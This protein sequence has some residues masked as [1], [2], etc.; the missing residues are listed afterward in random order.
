MAAGDA[1]PLPRKNAAF[2]WTFEMRDLLGALVTGAAGLDS[3]VSKDGGAF[4]DCTNEATEIGNGVYYL[5][6]TSTEMNADCVAVVVKTSTS[7]AIHPTI[8]LY[9]AEDADIRTNGVMQNGTAL[10]ARDMGASVL[11]SPGTGTGQVDLSAGVVKADNALLKTT[12]ATLYAQSIFDLAAGPSTNSAISG[13]ELLIRDAD[14]LTRFTSVVCNQYV[15]S[16]KNV[17]LAAG[18]TPAFTI[19]VG[20]VVYVM[21][22]APLQP[23]SHGRKITVDSL[24]QVAVGSMAADSITAA[25]I[26]S[27]AFTAAKFA[28]GA[29]DAV[30]SV[31]TRILTAGTNIVLAKGTGL[32][33][34]NDP[35]AA[36]NAA[37]TRDVSNLTPAADSF[38]AHAKAAATDIYIAQIHFDRDAANGTDEYSVRWFK[39]GAA[40]KTGIT[41]PTIQVEKRSDGT[42]LIAS[43]AMTSYGSTGGLKYDEATNRI[44]V[45]EAYTVWSRATIDG[46]QREWPTQ[47]SRDSTT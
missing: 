38:G 45:G 44:T 30:W 47:F 26:A 33:G 14:D 43:T 21:G 46:V 32:T 23:V 34:F 18:S 16:S 13:M 15:G 3:E 1:L 7:G 28:A 24:S 31:A 6:L 35:T 19:A 42:N 37:A 25:A 29:F 10:T 39:N 4:A 22:P 40:V 8:V 11:L 20:D 5:D 2:R 9:P 12:I 36:E 27:G 17:V 41:S